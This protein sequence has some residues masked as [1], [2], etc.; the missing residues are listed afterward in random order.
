MYVVDFFDNRVVVMDCELRFKHS[1]Q[2]FTMTYPCDV[3][4]LNDEVYVL[5]SEDDPCLH[6]FHKFGSKLRSLI[7]RGEGSDF[8][9]EKGSCFCLDKQNNILI[10]DYMAK[11]IKVFSPAGILLHTLGG[12]Q[13]ED[14]EIQPR[15]IIVTLNN[16]IVCS[17]EYTKFRLHIFY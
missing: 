1:I 14:K 4:T 2:H 8:Q 16:R 13:D 12:S 11:R 6:V 15:G 17:S 9:V 7:T 5:S 3:K 10:G